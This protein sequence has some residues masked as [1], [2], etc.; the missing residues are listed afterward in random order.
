MKEV[1]ED[2][3]G[4]K[5]IISNNNNKKP[6]FFSSNIYCLVLKID[7]DRMIEWNDN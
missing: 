4:A 5:L 2:K 6:Q 1:T 3:V 7:L